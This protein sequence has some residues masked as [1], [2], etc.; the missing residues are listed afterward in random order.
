MKI[1]LQSGS[2]TLFDGVV[3]AGVFLLAQKALQ[4]EKDG[5]HAAS[6][7]ISANIIPAM[8]GLPVFAIPAATI[9]QQPVVVS[10]DI[11]HIVHIGYEAHHSFGRKQPIICHVL[12]DE[13]ADINGNLILQ[14]RIAGGQH[15]PQ[16]SKVDIVYQ[17]P[18]RNIVI[19]LDAVV[20]A[21]GLYPLVLIDN[22][23]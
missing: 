10:T 4:G 14:L 5:I 20:D 13:A 8:Q 9:I 17:Y 7:I 22:P 2:H 12:L 18:H 16:L 21:A 23:G 3:Q 15:V 11:S 1:V 19:F 6:L